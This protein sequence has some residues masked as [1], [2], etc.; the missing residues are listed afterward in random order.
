MDIQKLCVLLKKTG[1]ATPFDNNVTCC[2][3]TLYH[4]LAPLGVNFI[5]SPAI[6]SFSMFQSLRQ[7]GL[8]VQGSCHS[9]GRL[10]PGQGNSAKAFGD[11]QKHFEQ[12]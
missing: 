1:I 6:C 9:R 4:D 2:L 12:R 8:T 11:L 5:G 10:C 7:P 3:T